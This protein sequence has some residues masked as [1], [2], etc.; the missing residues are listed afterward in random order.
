MNKTNIPIP[1]SLGKSANPLCRDVWEALCV[2][3]AC[4]FDLGERRG[5]MAVTGALDELQQLGIAE[6]VPDEVGPLVYR[7]WRLVGAE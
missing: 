7:R 3:P 6:P 2:R 4:A 5:M 1:P